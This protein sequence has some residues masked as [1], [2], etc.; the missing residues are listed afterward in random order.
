MGGRACSPQT[1]H[2]YSDMRHVVQCLLVL[3]VLMLHQERHPLRI[4]NLSS[5]QRRLPV[6]LIVCFC[7][8]LA[9]VIRGGAGGA[10]LSVRAVCLRCGEGRGRL[11]RGGGRDVYRGLPAKNSE[12]FEEG[13]PLILGVI[14]DES[15]AMLQG[16]R[17][18][19]ANEREP[20]ID[21]GL[22]SVDIQAMREP[23]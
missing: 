7:F 20:W 17:R 2:N 21:A 15:R 6:I 3:P 16:R 4:G 5:R 10:G 13:L 14:D 18:E 22:E 11:G 8:A 23:L 12:V 9:V 19:S 1:V